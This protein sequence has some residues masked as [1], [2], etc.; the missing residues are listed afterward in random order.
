MIHEPDQAGRSQ[1]RYLRYVTR[2]DC[3]NALYNEPLSRLAWLLPARFA[4][5]FR[6]RRAWNVDDPVGL[7]VDPARAVRER[8]V[9][10]RAIASRS[11]AHT[12]AS[13]EAAATAARTL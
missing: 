6:M 7:G 10:V 5:Y 2:N 9:R 1:Q 8:A 3:L 12:V 4:L 11:R 13:L